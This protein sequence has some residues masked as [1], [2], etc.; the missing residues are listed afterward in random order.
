MIKELQKFGYEEITNEFSNY[1]LSGSQTSSYKSVLL[2]A[3]FY[4]LK[5]HNFQV[6]NGITLISLNKIADY[7]FKFNFIIYKQ[8]NLRQLTNR[9]FRVKIYKIIDEQFADAPGIKVPKQ[10]PEIIRKK[11]IKLLFRNPIFLL[12]KDAY[13]YDFYDKEYNLIELKIDIEKEKEF[14]KLLREKNIDKNEILSIGIPQNIINFI[15]TQKTLLE[16]AVIANLMIFLEKINNVPNLTQ[17]IMIVD[18]DY[19]AERNIPDSDKVI[20]YKFQEQKCFYCGKNMGAFP[21]AD[22]FI[23]FNYLFDSKIWNI[24][25]ACRECN[26]KK[27]NFLVEKPYLKKIKNRNRSKKFI[28]EFSHIFEKEWEDIDQINKILEY[29]YNNCSLYFREIEL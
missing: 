22:H 26:R 2:K 1:F 29:H 9:N 23:P 15:K 21:E 12:R 18:G 20:L 27:S 17:K 3:I 8:F 4:N 14:N 5:I 19:Q 10:I 7:F 16:A 25:G 28:D 24:V 13:F 11:I 6:K